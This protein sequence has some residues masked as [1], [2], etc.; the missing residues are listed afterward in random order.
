MSK[1]QPSELDI[2]I[3]NVR[4][5]CPGDWRTILNSIEKRTRLPS[6]DYSANN[7]H[8]VKICMIKQGIMQ[9]YESMKGES[10]EPRT[11]N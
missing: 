5:A 8:I 10:N 9:I 11:T 1:P 4:Q 3:A 7:E 2:A 6:I